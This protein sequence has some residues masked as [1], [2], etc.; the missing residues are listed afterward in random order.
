MAMNGWL[1]DAVLHRP[2]T[3]L[4]MEP[5]V[6]CQRK[7]AWTPAV[8][9]PPEGILPY[10]N[11]PKYVETLEQVKGYLSMEILCPISLAHWLKD[12]ENG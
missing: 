12:V 11:W 10:V 7:H 4:V 3:P 8:P 6:V 5:L 2:K 9:E 1:P